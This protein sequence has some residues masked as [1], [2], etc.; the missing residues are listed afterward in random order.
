M[1]RFR[2]LFKRITLLF[3]TAS[4]AGLA[5]I[6]LI[7]VVYLLLGGDSGT[8]TL[9]VVSTLSALIEALTPGLLY[10]YDAADEP[11]CVD[12]G[13]RRNIK[14]KNTIINKRRHNHTHTHST[15]H[16]KS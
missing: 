6:S 16:Y 7:L 3:W 8:L 2:D 10:T 1:D 5:L 15:Q 14:N 13:G 9:S 4:E 12:L 11:P